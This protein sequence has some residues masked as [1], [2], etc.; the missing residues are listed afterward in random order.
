M[1]VFGSDQIKCSL[2]ASN[3]H[4]SY[5]DTAYEYSRLDGTPIDI[6]QEEWKYKYPKSQKRFDWK[7]LSH[8]PDMPSQIMQRVAFQQVFNSVERLTS[9]DIDY[10][11]NTNIKTDF[12]IAFLNDLSIFGDKKGVLAHA[13]F[14]F[15]NSKKN[16]VIEF[17]DSPQSNWYFTPLGWNVPGYL[18]D[19][20]HF[21]EGQQDTRGGLL[22]RASQPTVGIGMHE[23]RHSFG[24][25]HDLEDSTSLMHPYA[26]KGYIDGKLNKKA[27]QWTS[28]DIHWW[29]TYYGKSH[30]L[31][32]HLNRW[33]ALRVSESRYRRYMK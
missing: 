29:E 21:H 3:V 10:Q 25:R 9:L 33:R 14:Y 13:Y 5:I 22:M 1:P 24:G 23:L 8:T 12:T 6:G 17:N 11:K 2:F 32:R 18:V 19:P 30:I 26:Q 16:G 4:S 15:P 7:F 20:K 28:K 27:F 31:S